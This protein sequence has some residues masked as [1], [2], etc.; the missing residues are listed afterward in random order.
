[1]PSKPISVLNRSPLSSP[2]LL[3][4]FILE[5][6]A[7]QALLYFFLIYFALYSFE[8]NNFNLSIDDE[9]IAYSQ[10]SHFAELGRWVHPLVRAGFW[11]QPIVPY[12]PYIIFGFFISLSYLYVLR[13]FQIDHVEPF[14][15]LVFAAFVLHPVW[16]AQLEFSANIL[17]LGIGFL[18]ATASA[19]V[20]ARAAWQ[21]SSYPSSFT[22]ILFAAFGCAIAAGAY[23]SA[24]IVYPVIMLGVIIHNRCGAAG[25]DWS[26][27]SA[28]KAGAM[29][30]LV[31]FLS[32]PIYFLLARI[33]MVVLALEPSAYGKSLF[34]IGV[35]LADPFRAVLYTLEDAG[36]VYLGYW[37]SYGPLGY[38]YAA[39]ISIAIVFWLISCAQIS[40]QGSRHLFTQAATAATVLLLPAVFPLMTGMNMPLRVF[41]GVPV[42]FLFFGVLFYQS[43][44]SSFKKFTAWTL[45]ALCVMQSLYIHSVYQARTSVIQKHDLLLA[46]SLSKS[47]EFFVKPNGSAPVRVDFHGSVVPESVYPL[48]PTTTSGASFFEWDGG[49]P[50]RIVRYMN[51]IGYHPL[52]AVSDEEHSQLEPIYEGMPVWPE[53]GSIRLLDGILLVKLSE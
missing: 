51:M 22:S 30:A 43:A 4:V 32:I 18:A 8:I 47:M 45:L 38:A 13:S 21:A 7:L 44:T 36:R 52:V 14:Y 5:R 34:N 23:Q 35:F 28:R 39:T 19:L 29:T 16:I 50:W 41:I 42:V 49:N 24:I 27:F 48:L 10:V 37:M 2:S 15:F 26:S 11:P 1:M 53:T 17:P 25:N 40:K 3:S 20:T 9:V 12:G 46:A 31:V 6:S 33:T